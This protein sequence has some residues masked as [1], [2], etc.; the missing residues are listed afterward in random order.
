MAGGYVVAREFEF[1]VPADRG[2]PNCHAVGADGFA[3]L[4]EFVL[5]NREGDDPLELMR[6]CSPKGIGEAIQLRNYVG[7]VELAGGLQVEVL[8]KIDVA[9]TSG[10]DDR[11]VFARMLDEL[12][13]DVTFRPFDRTGLTTGKAPLFEVFVSMFL[14]EAADLVR[15]GIRSANVAVESEERYV[16]GRIDFTREARKSA[17][18]AHM[19]NIVHDELLPDQPENRLVKATLLHLRRRSRDGG[20]V[21]RA[22]LSSPPSPLE[23]HAPASRRKR[24]T[25]SET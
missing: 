8:P 7:V 3:A 12:G 19:T 21:R 23:R 11:K 9:S 13:S 2:R 25:A 18:R 20:N 15:R 1:L 4:R 6:L 14:D 22:R 10:T 5:A 17:A 16:R 24:S